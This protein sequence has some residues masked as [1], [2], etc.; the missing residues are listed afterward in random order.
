[1]IVEGSTVHSANWQLMAKLSIH[2]KFSF[3]NGLLKGIKF[4]LSFCNDLL[5]K[6][7]D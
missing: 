3:I 4:D 2:D 7:L 1:M 6:S 5:N